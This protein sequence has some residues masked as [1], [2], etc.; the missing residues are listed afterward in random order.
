M[1]SV[2]NSD[3][4][5]HHAFK[6]LEHQTAGYQSL[7]DI[8]KTTAIN[9]LRTDF[10]E[11]KS[12]ESWEVIETYNMVQ[13]NYGKSQ[14][15]GILHDR[16]GPNFCFG[17]GTVHEHLLAVNKYAGS[18]RNWP[19][20]RYCASILN[21]IIDSISPYI[22]SIL[23]NGK[24]LTVGVC[25]HEEYL[26]DKPLTPREIL[27]I[28][29]A[30]VYPLDHIQAVLQ[31]EII[32]YLGKLITTHRNLFTGILK[33]RVG[34]VIQAMNFYIERCSNKQQPLDSLSPSEIR[35]LVTKVMSVN[36]SAQDKLTPLERRQITGCLSR[37]PKDFY[38]RVWHILTKTP[39]GIRIAGSLL[40]QE[41]ISDMTMQELNFS[42][43]V[44]TF[45]NKL[46]LPEKRQIVVEMIMVVST[47]FQRNPELVLSGEVDLDK[48]R[49]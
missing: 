8:R 35:K 29:Y 38:E 4:K 17:G 22:T 11:Y 37:V 6:Q 39:G 42:L 3:I 49:I 5:A 19:V 45:L 41:N 21:Q 1:H 15:L 30:W 12:K 9:E 24:Q 32:L 27:Q 16:E 2:L 13:S 10:K 25:G 26:V 33:I 36:D 46:Q 20:V 31:Q 34:W 43:L 14:L 44:E 7:T 28:M 23:V 18:A 47:I 40:P 48:V